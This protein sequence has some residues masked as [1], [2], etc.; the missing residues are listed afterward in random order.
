M[1]FLTILQT[2]GET[3]NH[4][5]AHRYL[6]E[7]ESNVVGY[8]EKLPESRFL[9]KHVIANELG[10]GLDGKEDQAMF[11]LMKMSLPSPLTAPAAFIDCPRVYV[12]RC[13]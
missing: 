7:C 12:C 4:F 10:P 3:F 2:K 11:I 5:Q 1:G 13:V 6:D 8:Q 9:Q